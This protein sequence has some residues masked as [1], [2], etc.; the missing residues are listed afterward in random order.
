ML[1]LGF[2]QYRV[3]IVDDPMFSV[4]SVDNK[5]NHE[6]VFGEGDHYYSSKHAVLVYEEEQLRNSA[7][8]YSGG[9]A[10][11]VHE[12]SA[13][14]CNEAIFICCGFKLFSLSLPDLGLRWAARADDVCCF[15]VFAYDQDLIVHGEVSVSRID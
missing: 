9:G 10:T 11:G 7:L 2:E 15:G 5:I 3:E 6:S 8:V 12:N 4:G 13:T 14:I 1:D